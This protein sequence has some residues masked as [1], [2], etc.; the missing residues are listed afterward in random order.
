M[1]I[2]RS[3][4]ASRPRTCERPRTL[5]PCQPCQPCQPRSV[6]QS[7]SGRA[8]IREA[9]AGVPAKELSRKGGHSDMRSN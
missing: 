9:E 1:L 3:A 5:S 4:G 2:R 7:T 8:F 6:R